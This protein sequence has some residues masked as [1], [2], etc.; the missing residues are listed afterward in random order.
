[1]AQKQGVGSGK[2]QGERVEKNNEYN[3]DK[4][5][6]GKFREI[7]IGVI[8]KTKRNIKREQNRKGYNEQSEVHVEAAQKSENTTSGNVIL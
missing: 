6:V 7:K 4:K 8:N 5:E 2:E 3:S 1:M